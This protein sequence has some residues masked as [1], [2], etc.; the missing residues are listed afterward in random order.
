MFAV[1]ET[2]G[3]QY[4]V[5]PG[6]VLKV[7]KLPLDVG[8]TVELNAKLV[9]DDTGNIKTEGKVEAEVVEHGKH[10]KVLV[11]HFKRK[12]NYKKL[13]GHRQ[14]YTLIKIKEIKA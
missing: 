7:E 4:R 9:Q 13:N 11:F 14:P 8:E 12:K 1:I 3:K 10:K 6:T 2:G 5:E